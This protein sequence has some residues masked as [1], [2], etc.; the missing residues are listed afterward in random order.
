MKIM[1]TGGAGFIGSH[2][3]EAIVEQQLS[4]EVISVVD[5]LSM[6]D[7]SN[8]SNVEGSHVQ[9]IEQDLTN[10]ERVSQLIAKHSVDVVIHLAVTPLV[11]SLVEPVVGYDHIVAMQQNLLEC[12]RKGLFQRLISFSTSE[13][14]GGMA[15]RDV[16]TE[17]SP[18]NPAT[19]YAAAKA[20]ADL[21]ALSYVNSF[22]LDVTIVRPFN[23]YGPRKK[24]LKRA[25]I[26]PTV[27]R[28]LSRGLP[29]Q[30]YG[31]GV[32]S[33]DFVYVEDTVQA[34][35][36]VVSGENLSGEVLHVA[37]GESRSMRDV[38]FDVARLMDVEPI[39]EDLPARQGDVASLRG[40]MDKTK[41]LIDYAPA[42]TWE[43]GLKRCIE[44]YSRVC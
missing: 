42:T 17:E 3:V 21:L 22:D 16:I 27:I 37:S 10:Y 28:N 7:R 9:V 4:A 39:V 38:I 5:I 36:K 19:P 41:S 18:L 2:L 43:D 23:N 13:V 26:I 32:A 11:Y 15:G 35:L 14:Y 29:V 44:Y 1:V 24:V 33:R 6:G 25:G 20:S 8:L 40:S 34:V 30:L 31:G 12:Q